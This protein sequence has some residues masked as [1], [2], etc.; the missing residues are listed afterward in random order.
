MSASLPDRAT[1][2]G[3]KCSMNKECL[4]VFDTMSAFDRHRFHRAQKGTLC[5]H[6]KNGEIVYQ[7]PV[8]GV[9]LRHTRI[10]HERMFPGEGWP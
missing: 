9:G 4:R 6:P 1:L 7:V 10:V 3:Y 5:A 8:S 2:V